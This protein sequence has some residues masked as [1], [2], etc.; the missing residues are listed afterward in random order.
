[1]KYWAILFIFLSL[2][3]TSFAER[4]KKVKMKRD[5]IV[6]VKTALG[7]A[8]IISVADTPT[9]LV[10]GD[11]EAFKVEFLEQAI[12]IKPLHRNA[13]SNLYI[14][15]EYRRFDVQL[16]TVDEPSADYVVYLEN[17]VSPL[18]LKTLVQWKKSELK[19][20]ND[21]LTFRINRLGRGDSSLFIEF[22]VT[23]SKK[24]D[25]DPAWIWI[26]QRKSTIPIQRLVLSSLKMGGGSVSGVIEI[27]KDDLDQSKPFAFEVKRKAATKVDISRAVSW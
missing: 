12:T 11:N 15:T 26:S 25:L 6:Q 17:V 7:V 23:G 22:E 20:N 24:L 4:V 13:K 5:Q 3:Q 9:S 14:Y 16:V 18:K 2:P 19:F 21:D 10:V 1:M 8:T 27:Q